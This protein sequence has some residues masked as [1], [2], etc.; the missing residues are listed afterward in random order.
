MPAETRSLMRR[1]DP[2]E[3]ACLKK[4]TTPAGTQVQLLRHDGIPRAAETES[5][6]F[7]T[8][9]SAPSR[10]VIG[11]ASAQQ[12]LAREARLAVAKAATPAKHTK[13]VMDTMDVKTVGYPNDVNGFKGFGCDKV[14]LR[15]CYIM[16]SFYAH[17]LFLIGFGALPL[18]E[19]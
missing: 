14:A 10:P 17:R 5:R 16:V 18:R 8:W 2:D 19:E 11:S 4:Q 3:M 7:P 6:A 15:K 12:A 1:A 9:S 13:D